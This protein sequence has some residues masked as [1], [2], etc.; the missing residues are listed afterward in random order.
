M[1]KNPLSSDMLEGSY[2]T[3][4]RECQ[5]TRVRTGGVEDNMFVTWESS[6][7]RGGLSFW[8]L[9]GFQ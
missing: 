9:G 2:R 3:P 8:F 6:D 1:A 4:S 7:R 5:N